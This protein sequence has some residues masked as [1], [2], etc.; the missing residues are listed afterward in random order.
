MD[1]K[2]HTNK[3]HSILFRKLRSEQCSP[4]SAVDNSNASLL[5]SEGA[6]SSVF[7]QERGTY[8]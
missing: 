4:P 5:I 2:K 1:I 3:I 6:A 8:F 7:G